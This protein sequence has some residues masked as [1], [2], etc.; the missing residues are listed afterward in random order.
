[1]KRLWTAVV[2]LIVTAVA[3]CGGGGGSSG[4]SPQPRSQKVTNAGVTI[5]VPTGWDT[6]DLTRPT[7]VAMAT[8]EADLEAAAPTGPRFIARA[9]PKDVP[10]AAS[11]IRGINRSGFTGTPQVGSDTVDGRTATTVEWTQPVGGRNETTRLVVATLGRGLAYTFTMQAPQSLWQNDL[12]TASNL[13]ATLL[14]VKF[15]VDAIR[16]AG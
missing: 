9:T 16:A 14:S 5:D 1:M 6:K 13:E 12:E 15:D 4:S 11:L 2:L 10:S 3:G 7:G 8:N